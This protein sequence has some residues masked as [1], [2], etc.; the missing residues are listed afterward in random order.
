MVF[1]FAVVHGDSFHGP[2]TSPGPK[3]KAIVSSKAEEEITLSDIMVIL[4]FEGPIVVI[5]V[6]SEPFGVPLRVPWK[7]GPLKEG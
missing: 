6:D 2:G 1:W 7:L 4:P 3:M 5:E